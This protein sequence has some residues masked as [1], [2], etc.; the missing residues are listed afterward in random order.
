MKG[1]VDLERS[2]ENLQESIYKNKK[3]GT[4]KELEQTYRREVSRDSE[5]CNETMSRLQVQ[6]KLNI[7]IEL[8]FNICEGLK[9]PKKK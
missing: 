1:R 6:D 3:I 7:I 5:V 4:I 9:S 8:L 2:L